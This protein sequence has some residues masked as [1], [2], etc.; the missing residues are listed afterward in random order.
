MGLFPCFSKQIFTMGR[1][2]KKH[3]KRLAAP[4]H[5]MLDKLS[6]TWAPKASAGPHKGRVCLP[7]AVFLRNRLKYAL[8]YDEVKKICMQRLIKVD[9]KVR[10]DKCYP[11]GLM[12]VISIEQTGEN[13]R[14][15]LD[16]KGRFAVHRITDE[17][18]SYKICKVNKLWV[19]K[20]KIPQIN[21][22]DGRTIRYP[23]PNVRVNDTI[24]LDLTTGKIID[25]V[26]FEVG[27]LALITGGNN[28]G[29][30]GVL[31]HRDRNHGSFDIVT[32]K[33][34]AGATFAT[35]L[36]FC[37]II[38]K[39]KEPFIS[40]PAGKGVKLTIADERDRR[41]AAKRAA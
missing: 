20:N 30:I 17:E 5:W 26:K 38:G 7:V 24:K 39:G 36:N 1:G 41:L 27:N 8:N 32:V 6:G 11:A 9:N 12:D 15:V 25:H 16:I 37:M 10:T 29:R 14:L 28:M 4:K 21:T 34:A 35:R 22:H 23:D 13:F 40:L 3:L 33:D 19:G 18:A 2:P 31:Q